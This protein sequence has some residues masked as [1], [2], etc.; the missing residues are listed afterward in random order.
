MAYLLYRGIL[1]KG[2]LH[3]SLALTGVP[4]VDVHLCIGVASHETRLGACRNG[5]QRSWWRCRR[6]CDG[7]LSAFVENDKQLHDIRLLLYTGEH[8][9]VDLRVLLLKAFSNAQIGHLCYVSVEGGVMG[10]PACTPGQMDNEF[11]KYTVNAP[12]VMV[13]I[14]SETGKV[15]T[16]PGQKGQVLSPISCGG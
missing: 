16:E 15:I 3:F 6:P 2:F 7:W 9:P 8:L 11:P 12:D 10:I 14:V 13:E 1:Y 5:A 4:V